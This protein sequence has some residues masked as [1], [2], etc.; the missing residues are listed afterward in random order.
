MRA[1]R[2][3]A[4]PATRGVHVAAARGASPSDVRTQQTTEGRF[5]GC[6]AVM[7]LRACFVTSA[8]LFAVASACEDDRG[9]GCLF[10]SCC[11][12]MYCSN[13]VW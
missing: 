4:I 6:A 9:G 1:L 13:R 12:G 5:F 3:G 2:T 10:D 7:L 11:A 8:L